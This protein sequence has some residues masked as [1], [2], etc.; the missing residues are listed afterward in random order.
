MAS[1]KLYRVHPKVVREC[2]EDEVVI[3]NLE[4]GNYYSLNGTG[5]QIWKE[6]ESSGIAEAV[7]AALV[8]R[9]EAPETTIRHAVESFIR[10][11]EEQGLIIGAE[12]VAADA[13]AVQPP[14]ESRAMFELPV[15]SVFSDMQ[16]LL[17]LDPIHDV[18]ESGWP[19][20]PADGG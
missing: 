16:D 3:I 13:R 12:S 19:A 4:N 2:F 8:A 14:V 15:L 6:L 11:L 5:A 1:Y 9:Y 17:L 10:Q 7:A 20:R 18:D